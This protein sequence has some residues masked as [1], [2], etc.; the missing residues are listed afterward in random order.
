M[1]QEQHARE[2]GFRWGR[3]VGGLA[4][5]AA[6]ALWVSPQTAGAAEI[7]D[8]RRSAATTSA[9]VGLSLDVEKAPFGQV[10][11]GAHPAAHHDQPRRLARGGGAR[12]HACA[13]STCTGCSCSTSW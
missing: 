9:T 13:S 2:V 7:G 1:R 11:R 8:P 12:S 6:L 3:L 10:V 5:L 4:L